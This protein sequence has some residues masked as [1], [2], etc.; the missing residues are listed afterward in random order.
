M[1][2]GLSD[3]N[4]NI[5]TNLV[6]EP[7][8]KQNAK[9]YIFGSRATGKHHPFSDIDILVDPQNSIVKI[10]TA[11]IMEDIEESRFPIKVD[12]VEISNLVE[13]YK[14]NVFKQMVE[15]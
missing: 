6:I 13:N 3:E 15:V 8:K 9:V 5:L 10:S 4:F 7:L 2:F 11:K 1:K 14:S 12:L